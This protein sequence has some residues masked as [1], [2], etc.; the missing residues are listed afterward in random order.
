MTWSRQQLDVLLP[1]APNPSKGTR[2]RQPRQARGAEVL[3]P[4]AIPN[5]IPPHLLERVGEHVSSLGAKRSGQTF[6]LVMLCLQ[7]GW[8][9]GATLAFLQQYKHKPSLR[10]YGKALP[11]EV[12]SIY[13]K[14][15]HAGRSCLMARCTASTAPATKAAQARYRR[16]EPVVVTLARILAACDNASWPGMAGKSNAALLAANVSMAEEAGSLTYNA[17]RRDLALR[18]CVNRKTVDARQRDLIQDGWL[19][20]VDDRTCRRDSLSY[21]LTVVE[22]GPHFSHPGG[23]AP[24][25]TCGP[26]SAR[27]D[28]FRYGKGIGKTAHA[29]YT[30]L[31][32]AP[33]TQQEVAAL[34]S[35]AS[36]TA[37]K[38]LKK[39]SDMGMVKQDD[40]GYW[41]AQD[42]D[43]EALAEERGVLG[44]GDRQR[45]QHEQERRQWRKAELEKRRVEMVYMDIEMQKYRVLDE[46]RLTGMSSGW[47]AAKAVRQCEMAAQQQAANQRRKTGHLGR[48]RA[49]SL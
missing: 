9:A 25:R 34:A 38:A 12:A 46:Y 19:T 23:S 42:A 47:K 36:D 3:L 6:A 1:A 16:G 44:R 7:Q 21:T 41:H 5:V 24:A 2:G 31:E 43:H 28:L 11:D 26:S 15:P 17:S 49:R 32:E 45:E 40:H 20:Q 14:H 29:I 22:D 8:S 48:D 37:R 39:M 35:C 33:R 27:A 4:A 10:K 18:A 13:D 30:A